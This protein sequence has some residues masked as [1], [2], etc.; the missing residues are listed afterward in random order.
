MNKIIDQIRG[1][2]KRERSSP[3]KQEPNKKIKSTS[4]I[5]TRSKTAEIE[6]DAACYKSFC[7]QSAAGLFAILKEKEKESF[8]ALLELCGSEVLSGSL[9]KLMVDWIRGILDQAKGPGEEAAQAYRTFLEQFTEIVNTARSLL[10][11]ASPIEKIALKK[12]LYCLQSIACATLT[13]NNA[14][15]VQADVVAFVKRSQFDFFPDAKEIL[16]LSL[17]E[18]DEGLLKRLATTWDQAERTMKRLGHPECGLKNI[19][20]QTFRIIDQ[21]GRSTTFV[22]FASP[23]KEGKTPLQI[24]E[25]MLAHLDAKGQTHIDLSLLSP[26][27]FDKEKVIEEARLAS[28]NSYPGTVIPWS[29]DLYSDFSWRLISKLNIPESCSKKKFKGILKFEFIKTTG[30]SFVTLPFAK[31]GGMEMQELQNAIDCVDHDFFEE[32]DQLNTHDM[33]VF[34]DMT[35]IYLFEAVCRI[36]TPATCDTACRCHIDRGMYFMTVLYYYLL[37]KAGRQDDGEYLDYMETMIFAPSLLF[38]QRATHK[39]VMARLLVTLSYLRRPGAAQRIQNRN[40]F[41]SGISV[42]IPKLFL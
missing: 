21:D 37:C 40:S 30:I 27:T 38:Y 14:R 17:N 22:R 13:Q 24:Y 15:K 6:R 18:D 7:L 39:N 10:A 2:Y 41:F 26:S 33:T 32:I 23:E 19:P 34:I 16:E 3:A 29:F 35:M 1:S 9:P 11:A 31:E 25:A 4:R 28:Q 5:I 36:A 42:K 8:R 20:N 12:A